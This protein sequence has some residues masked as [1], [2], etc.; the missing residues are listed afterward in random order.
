M[1][2]Q[3]EKNFW[4]KGLKTVIG[5]DEAG[6][7]PLAGPVVAAAAAVDYF[8]Y[9]KAGR[10]LKKDF[11]IIL[12]QANDSKKLAAKKREEIYSLIAKSPL[13]KWGIAAVSEK[14][15]DKINIFEAS[16][17]AMAKAL[18]DLMSKDD[19]IG[20]R[21]L[22]K[23]KP[24]F[25]R[26]ED[27]QLLIDGNFLLSSDFLNKNGFFQAS[28][29]AIVK[30]DEK[31]FS[32]AAASII[33]KVYRDKIM[34]KMD[35]KYPEY[36]FAKHKGYATKHHKKMLEVFGPADIHRKSFQPVCFCIKIK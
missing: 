31:V 28:Q 10:S 1:D 19:F 22:D 24:N 3:A 34:E 4:D 17:L 12:K 9:Q 27:Q 25:F 16:K 23:N 2:L 35:K 33:A 6:R 14:K 13:I 21:P 20:K 36:G 18:I 29:Q 11:N 5:I 7:G 26:P 32:I 15:I 8:S 30:G